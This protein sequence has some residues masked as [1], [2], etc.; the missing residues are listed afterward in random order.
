MAK[1][2]LRN[3][4]GWPRLL[5]AELRIAEPAGHSDKISCLGARQLLDHALA[6]PLPL[7]QEDQEI[8]LRGT[9]MAIH[10]AA[11]AWYSWISPPRTSCRLIEGASSN[12][13]TG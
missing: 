2:R 3:P 4:R 11:T 13:A 8:G 12:G 1:R 9:K 10:H 6:G 5:A 7:L